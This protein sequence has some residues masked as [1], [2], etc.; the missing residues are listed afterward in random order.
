VRAA[1][2]AGVRRV[3]EATANRD[4][5]QGLMSARAD[6]LADVPDA[7]D[8]ASM[9]DFGTPAAAITTTVDVRDY[10]D[11]KRAAMAAHESQIP[12]ESFFLQL[13]P[14]QFREAFG[15][16]W[17]IRRDAPSVRESWLFDGL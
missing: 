9:D 11:A 5:I 12:A 17:F 15:N 14:E 10:V 16:E 2:L 7:P 4:F 6:E 1:D 3:Y 13:A 8:A